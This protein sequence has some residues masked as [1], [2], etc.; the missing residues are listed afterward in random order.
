MR[1]SC[2]VLPAL[3]SS[4]P[5]VRVNSWV[6]LVQNYHS[7]FAKWE[8]VYQPLP[9]LKWNLKV[10]CRFAGSDLLALGLSGLV[11]GPGMM[12][13][14]YGWQH[15][16]RGPS[17]SPP[18]LPPHSSNR[19]SL[20]LHLRTSKLS[21]VCALFGSLLV[22]RIF[23]AF[24]SHLPQ[25]A[26]HEGLSG[27]ILSGQGPLTGASCLWCP[28]KMTKSMFFKPP[29]KTIISCYF[30]AAPPKLSGKRPH[31]SCLSRRRLW[32]RRHPAKD[33][34]RCLPMS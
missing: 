5:I 14:Y 33:H 12:A 3:T 20:C 4:E 22:P 32:V 7:C 28:F 6:K 13:C 34:W 16:G 8:L 26:R 25:S 24:L 21:L 10:A 30:Y 23:P 2:K 29:H 19:R 11:S 9:C 18:Y 27:A 31:W 17:D 15:Q 1:R